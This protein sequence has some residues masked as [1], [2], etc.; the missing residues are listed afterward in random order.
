VKR[1][2]KTVL[3]AALTVA[4]AGISIRYVCWTNTLVGLVV[5]LDNLERA[6]NE[7]KTSGSAQSPNVSV[8]ALSIALKP[9]DATH[10]TYA[11]TR[12]GMVVATGRARSFYLTHWATLCIYSGDGR[13]VVPFGPEPTLSDTYDCFFRP[14]WCNCLPE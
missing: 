6:A 12:A 13:T 3:L 9:L 1:L 11:V 7:I 10:V 5:K 4:L 8:G 2:S 14:L